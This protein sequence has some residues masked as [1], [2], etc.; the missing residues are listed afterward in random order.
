MLSED[1]LGRERQE[2]TVNELIFVRHEVSLSGESVALLATEQD[3]AGRH[4]DEPIQR[5][6]VSVMDVSEPLGRMERIAAGNV[7]TSSTICPAD[8]DDGMSG[9]ISVDANRPDETVYMVDPDRSGERDLS[10][11]ADL[12][13]GSR[14]DEQRREHQ[15]DSFFHIF[16]EVYSR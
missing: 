5:H 7:V 10:L 12:P 8:T 16:S 11:I 3:T 9:N 4:Q 15:Y 2:H 14:C 6:G 13:A 1:V